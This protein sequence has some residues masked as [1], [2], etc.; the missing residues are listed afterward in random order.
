MGP[1]LLGHRGRDPNDDEGFTFFR[2]GDFDDV[3]RTACQNFY[4]RN[5]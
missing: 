5:C 4:P 2:G 1:W 3:I